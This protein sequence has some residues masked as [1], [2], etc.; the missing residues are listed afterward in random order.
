VNEMIH[1]S[2]LYNFRTISAF[3]IFGFAFINLA[4]GQVNAEDK[5]S[6]AQTIQMHL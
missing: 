1:K 6:N 4:I 5:P 3:L 2:A